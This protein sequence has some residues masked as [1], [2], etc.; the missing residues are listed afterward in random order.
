MGRQE[1]GV[2]RPALQEMLDEIAGDCSGCGICVEE[3]GFLTR[4]GSP[5]AIALA[6]E[7]EDPRWRTLAFECSLCSLCQAVCPTNVRPDALFLEMRREA[8]HR[9]DAL[10]APHRGL[11]GY[12]RMGTSALLSWYGLPAGCDTVFFPG[13]ALPGTRPDTTR[14]VFLRLQREI[15]NIGIMLDC[16]TKPSHDLGRETTFDA[17]FGEVRER[18]RAHGIT[19]VLVACP[20]CHKMFTEH[21]PEVRTV[22]VYEML[23]LP[24]AARRRDMTIHDP[25]VLRFA[26]GPQE[27]V[28]RL[29]AAACGEI[30]EMP[31]SRETTLCCGEGGDVGV[32]DA[33]LATAWGERRAAEVGERQVVT[34][35]A[36]CANHLSSRMSIT[37]ILDLVTDA[38]R[39][40][41]GKAR[42][43]SGWATYWN[44]LRLKMRLKKDVV[45]VAQGRRGSRLPKSGGGA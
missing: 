11:I 21:A 37:H 20:N 9:D 25:C 2:I 29:A 26:K 41:D 13:C 8:V 22:S 7:P 18:L 44:R 35:C 31:H 32:V 14:G 40:L 23:P 36:G 17:K 6:Y 28:R 38:D 12:E 45:A 27:A 4:H 39:A 42:V 43:S 34:Y 33:A 24:E 15:P 10:L 1:R 3:C 16:C 30:S 5:S 19:R